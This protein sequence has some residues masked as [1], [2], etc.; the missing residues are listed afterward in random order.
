[1]ANIS[2]ARQQALLNGLARA[3]ALKNRQ[4]IKANNAPNFYIALKAINAHSQAFNLY[5]AIGNKL[6][7]WG[8]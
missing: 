6:N 1:M 7:A 2:R 4:A 5:R 8:L 3:R